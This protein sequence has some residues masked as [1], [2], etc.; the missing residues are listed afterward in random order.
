MSKKYAVQETSGAYG[1]SSHIPESAWITV[2]EFDGFDAANKLR[3]KLAGEMSQR[4]GPNAWDSH[5][6]IIA[7]VDTQITYIHFCAGHWVED[8]PS[9]H[10]EFCPNEAKSTVDWPAGEPQPRAPHGPEEWGGR[11]RC[12]SCYEKHDQYEENLY[13]KVASENV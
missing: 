8:W 2:K 4:C 9:D 12:P 7:L 6:Q 1:P 13:N 3:N 10:N 11:D 5:R